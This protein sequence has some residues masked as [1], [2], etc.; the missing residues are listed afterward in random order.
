MPDSH[1]LRA[2]FALLAVLMAIIAQ[3]LSGWPMQVRF[4]YAPLNYW[5]AA[6]LALLLP[7][8]V[9]W[10]ALR[11]PRRSLKIAGL[12]LS[13]VV[14][15]PS[16]VFV[17]LAWLEWSQ[18]TNNVDS[19]FELLSEGRAESASY[20]L[21]RTDC[22]ATCANGLVLRKEYDSP[23]GFKLVSPVWSLNRASEGTVQVQGSVVRI[24]NGSNVLATIT[25]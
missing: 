20:R 24:V 1:T 7:L 3:A 22:G 17:A 23:F 4:G 8:T 6:A 15:L 13:A 5:A 11:L 25:P 9:L 16:L 14:A 19:S 21:Y 10:V 18:L 12:V 2:P